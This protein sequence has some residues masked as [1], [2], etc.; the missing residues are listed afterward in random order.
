ME[1]KLKTEFVELDNML[2]ALH[3][4]AS[5]AQARQC[6]QSSSIK[7]NGQ[8][9]IRIRRKLRAGDS[10]EFGQQTISIVA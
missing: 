10:V 9:E 8:V 4:V 7:V 3:L 1:F 5:G 6:I 2:K